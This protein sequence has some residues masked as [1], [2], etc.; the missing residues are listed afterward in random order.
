M[1]TAPTMSGPTMTSAMHPSISFGFPAQPQFRP[2]YPSGFVQSPLP[3]FN[4]LPQIHTLNEQLQALQQKFNKSGET[5]DELYDQVN[6]LKGELNEQK[7]YNQRNNIL[8]HGWDDVP[9]APT[10]PTQE[11]A[12][13]FTN[14]V[15]GR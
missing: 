7:Q 4:F 8:A 11:F 1:M 3:N 6:Y 2:Q 13:E 15:V 12:E 14:H 10:K 9:I 5:I